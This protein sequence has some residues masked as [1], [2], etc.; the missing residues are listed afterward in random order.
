MSTAGQ[1]ALAKGLTRDFLLHHRVCPKGLDADG[2]LVVAAA[3]AL[4]G[5]AD[6]LA[7]LYN[8]RIITEPV[9]ECEPDTSQAAVAIIHPAVTA[10]QKIADGFLFAASRPRSIRAR[11]VSG[12][13]AEVRAPS[14]A[15]A[16]APS[17]LDGRTVHHSRNVFHSSRFSERTSATG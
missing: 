11:L 7:E 6:E 17:T 9:I 14:N 3:D 16:S 2:A 4:P 5:A 15:N 1:L 12:R 13:R 10:L 8:R